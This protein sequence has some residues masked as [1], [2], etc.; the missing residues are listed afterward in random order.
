MHLPFEVAFY[1]GEDRSKN[2]LQL[3]VIVE[4][5]LLVYV[6]SNP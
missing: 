4:T 1:G 3:P 2:S 5:E 6:G